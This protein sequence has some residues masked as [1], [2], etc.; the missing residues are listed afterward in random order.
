MFSRFKFI[1]FS[2]LAFAILAQASPR[3]GLIVGLDTIPNRIRNDNPSLAAARWKIAE[4]EGRNL[5]SGRY[6][7]PV[8]S[9]GIERNDTRQEGRIEVGISQ[10]FPL[11]DRLS[12]EK[13]V[14][15]TEIQIASA[16]VAD[17]ERV[18]IQEARSSLVEILAI[19]QQLAL[20]RKSIA[21]SEEFATFVSEA[22]RRAELSPLDAGQARLESATLRSDLTRL[23]AAEAAAVGKLK[24]LLG[25]DPTDILNVAGQSLPAPEFKQNAPATMR[26]DYRAS[27]LEAQ[28]ARESVAL[29]KARKYD[30]IEVGVVAGYERTEDAPE[31]FENEATL[32]VQVSLP[33]PFWNKN[34]G[35]IAAAE[36]TARRR[37]QEG[38][39]LSEQIKN[40]AQAAFAEMR[41]W[42]ALHENIEEE[43][44]PLAE[45]QTADTENAYRQGLGDLQ[46]FLRAREQRLALSES[47]IETLRNFQ[48]ARIRYEAAL[49]I[50]S[51]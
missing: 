45:K 20:R 6:E 46:S 3:D 31:G 38:V 51:N 24:P 48:L 49:S 39:A 9:A 29:E 27:L 2:I 8:L 18:L 11:T 1:Q 35:N 34:E 42:A 50:S 28:A 4:A 47:K 14:T 5:A 37:E 36:A 21:L 17:V 10:R 7:N 33:L 44:V 23:T 12:L 15:A 22:S 40:E 32:G 19:R 30:D 13:K 16:E 26:P 43:L 25:M 41:E